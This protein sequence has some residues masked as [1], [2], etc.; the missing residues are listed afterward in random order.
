MREIENDHK[1]VSIRA[2]S[3]DISV[4]DFPSFRPDFDFN[5]Q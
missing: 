2:Q 4:V 5:R 1:N 3:S